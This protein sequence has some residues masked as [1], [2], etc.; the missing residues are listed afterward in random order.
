MQLN[1]I[2]FNL[3]GIAIRWYGILIATG[4]LVALIIAKIN[5]KF[6]N[7][8]YDKFI[9]C[10]LISLPFGI[11][12]ARLYYVIFNYKLYLH[13]PIDVLNIR[14]GGLAIH[15]GIIF[16]ILAAYIYSKRRRI[17]LLTY[18]DLAAPSIV[19]AQSIGRWGNFFNQ[20]AHGGEVSKEF[21]SK[22]PEFI[23]RGMFIDGKYYHPTF[24]YESIW[25]L[26]TF[27]FLMFIIRYIITKRGKIF[28]IYIL[29]YSIGRFFIEALRTDSLM[30]G[31]FRTAQIISVIG[32]LISIIYLI[33]NRGKELY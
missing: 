3:F 14:Q 21:I 11:I 4:M 7:V 29:L 22:F 25:N 1:P 13:N 5:S 31:P 24:L 26:I 17:N 27:I 10:A 8:D 19:L 9:D 18:L 15:G 32:I 12:G 6:L 20:E 33:S 2:A 30:I 28:F 23:Q 16:G